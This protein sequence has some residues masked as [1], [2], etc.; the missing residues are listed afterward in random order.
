MK[1]RIVILLVLVAVAVA[2]VYAYRGANKTP[3]NRIVVSGNIELTEV[4]I[5]FKTAGRLIERTVDEGDSVKK[6]QVIA[7]LDRDQLVAQRDREVA[8]LQSAESQLAQAKTA[9]EWEKDTLAGRHRTACGRSGV[10][11]S[12][13]GR[14]EERR[15]PAGKTGCPSR[16]GFG[17]VGSGA[18]P[19]GLGPRAGAAPRRRHLHRAIRPISQSLGDRRGGAQ[20]RQRAAGAG[21]GRSARRSRSTPSRRRW[22]ACAARSKWRRPTRSK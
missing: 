13:P 3:E 7:R 21:A 22:S 18:L 1:K 12:A 8:G 16:G 15:A 10:Q 4:N 5:A 6:G 19:E 14:A 11:R 17:A 2:G 20:L 9:L